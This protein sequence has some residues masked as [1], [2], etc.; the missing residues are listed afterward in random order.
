MIDSFSP[1]ERILASLV[2][3]GSQPGE[4]RD[5]QWE[6]LIDLALD[7]GLGGMLL[8]SLRQGGYAIQGDS[9]WQS[10]VDAA[11]SS[12]RHSLL[13]E[14]ARWLAA[15]SFDQAGIPAIWLKG[16]ALSHTHYPEPHLR[17]MGDLDVLVPKDGLAAAKEALLAQGFRP[18]G[19]DFFELGGFTDQARH[20]ECLLSRTGQV[21]LE[22]HFRLLVPSIHY[23]MED[24]DLNWFWSQTQELSQDRP[25]FQVLKPEAN[26]LHLCGH[27]M[28][29]NQGERLD[30]L[31]L[32]DL[33]LLV[34]K[35]ALDWDLIIEQ[36]EVLHW[37][38]A[39]ETALTLLP[40]L[41]GT[42]LPEKVLGQLQQSRSRN[43]IQPIDIDI[44]K[45]TR[46][47]DEWRQ[48]FGQMTTIQ[49]MKFIWITLFPP[50]VFLRYQY[51]LSPSK[52]LL[53]YYLNHFLS[54][55]HEIMRALR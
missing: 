30:L 35:S 22:L 34:T 23:R 17:T 9:R 27:V 24:S 10:L 12:G 50:A 6:E 25:S 55:W 11:R 7:H 32:L 39:V 42:R 36:A 52:S 37:A 44:Y 3:G 13:I 49:R 43:G 31:H 1:S 54:G 26:L 33:H 38:Y 45:S 21:K 2:S 47:W 40:A 14:K 46:R 15:I 4:I 29:Q 48:A 8:W 18:A 28:L 16:I 5:E 53:P 20:H 41:F 19:I 51:G